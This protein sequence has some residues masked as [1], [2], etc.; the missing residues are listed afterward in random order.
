MAHS[1]QF[2]VEFKREDEFVEFLIYSLCAVAAYFVL[3]RPK[4]EK[5]A[6]GILMGSFGVAFI[7]YMIAVSTSFVPMVTV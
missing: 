4:R 6:F 2:N 7:M 1:C 5:L 3:F